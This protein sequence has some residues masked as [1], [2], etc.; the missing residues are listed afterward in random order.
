METP[1]PPLNIANSQHLASLSSIR[2]LKPKHKQHT[3][4]STST[5]RKSA[6]SPSG[7]NHSR[8]QAYRNRSNKPR[9]IY[10]HGEPQ[11]EHATLRI[12]GR[13][14]SARPR[15]GGRPIDHWIE[16]EEEELTESVLDE[17]VEGVAVAVVGELVVARGELLEALRRDGGEVAGELRVLGQD[18]RA[19]GHERVDQRLLPHVLLPLSLPSPSACARRR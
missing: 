5:P 9:E 13:S 12:R 16:E 18:D 7:S 11:I 4:D 3:L 6:R 8:P 14:A 17:V 1:E 19:A 10:T 15:R 2:Q